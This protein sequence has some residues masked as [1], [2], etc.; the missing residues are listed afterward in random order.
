MEQTLATYLP[1]LLPHAEAVT[2]YAALY[3]G[4][5]TDAE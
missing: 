5:K 4:V 1:E 3:F 2:A